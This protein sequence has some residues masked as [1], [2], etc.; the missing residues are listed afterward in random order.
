MNYC[1]VLYPVFW[2]SMKLIFPYSA[3]D[4]IPRVSDSISRNSAKYRFY[5]NALGWEKYYKKGVLGGRGRGAR[6]VSDL[7][8]GEALYIHIYFN[9]NSKNTAEV[10]SI[11]YSV[12]N[13]RN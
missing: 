8:T 12:R 5:L 7:E 6:T 13:A 2:V 11:T 4:G 1:T 10:W 9:S 3:N